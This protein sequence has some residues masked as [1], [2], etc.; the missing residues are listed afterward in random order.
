MSTTSKALHVTFGVL[1][2]VSQ[3][4]SLCKGAITLDQSFTPP[5]AANLSF[6]VSF[7]GSLGQTFTAGLTGSLA[8]VRVD[9][10]AAR[11]SQLQVSIY[12]AP[13]GF[14]SL[15]LLGS[16]LLPS[17]SSSISDPIVFSTPVNIV[18]GQ[19]YL[20]AIDYPL[21][22][23]SVPGGNSWKGRTSNAYASGTTYYRSNTNGIWLTYGSYDLFFQT[24]VDVAS[25]TPEPASLTLW[26]L[27]ALGCIAATYHQRRRVPFK[28]FPGGE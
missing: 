8:E 23:T 3:L 2:T 4:A 5:P 11:S 16:V 12:E 6:N 17:A 21:E 24:Y 26:S 10:M 13:G 14:P 15:A 1:I 25:P 19:S 18:A 7:G 28:Q 27:G 22:T 9:V 20:L